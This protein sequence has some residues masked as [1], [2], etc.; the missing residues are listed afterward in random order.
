MTSVKDGKYILYK[1]CKENKGK[2]KNRKNGKIERIVLQ[3]MGFRVVGNIDGICV[4]LDDSLFILYTYQTAHFLLFQKIQQ[5]V[6]LFFVCLFFVVAFAFLFNA[7]INSTCL[8]N[9]DDPST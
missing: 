5:N 3:M 9:H 1:S 6:N 4:M 7:F 8:C 2:Q